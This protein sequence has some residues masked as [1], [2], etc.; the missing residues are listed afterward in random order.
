MLVAIIDDGI[1]T[2]LFDVGPLEYDMS[3]TRI[4]TVRPRKA[5][6]I[7]TT[8]HGTTIAAIIKKY[9]PDATFCSVRIFIPQS[10]GRMRTSCDKLIAALK[11]CLKKEIPIINL[12]LGTV[13]ERDFKKLSKII[14]QL[15]KNGHTVVAACNQNGKYTLPA[16]YPGVLGVRFDRTL[17][18][19]EYIKAYTNDGIDFIA[20][21]N[22][23][24]YC[25]LGFTYHTQISNSY[26]APTITAAVVNGEISRTHVDIQQL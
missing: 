14:N 1:N 15:L 26:A 6:E 8:D 21:S 20:S 12:S 25:N 5:H 23:E 11:W 9:A 17:C 24:L 2:N 4:N 13:D 18:E 22:H 3:I 16:M 19:N 10:Q 7:I